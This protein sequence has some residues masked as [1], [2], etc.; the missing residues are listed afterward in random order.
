MART[1]ADGTRRS[2]VVRFGGLLGDWMALVKALLCPAPVS[3]V[4]CLECIGGTSRDLDRER[5][6]SGAERR[7]IKQYHRWHEA[8]ILNPT[9]EAAKAGFE[10]HQRKNILVRGFYIFSSLT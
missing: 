8:L 6:S 5:R 9:D 4:A 2:A 1:D 3:N 7:D 10:Q